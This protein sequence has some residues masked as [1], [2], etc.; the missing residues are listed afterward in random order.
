MSHNTKFSKDVKSQLACGIANICQRFM[1]VE[2]SSHKKG[3]KEM[4][5]FLGTKDIKAISM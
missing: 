4:W 1:C 2:V 5:G 3:L